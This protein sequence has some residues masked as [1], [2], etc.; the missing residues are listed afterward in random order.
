VIRRDYTA[1]RAKCD[2]EG[3][4]RICGDDN[5]EAAHIIPRSQVAPP[6]GEHEDNIVPLCRDCH[7][8]YDTGRLDILPVLTRREQ[9]KAVELHGL[10]GALRRITNDRHAA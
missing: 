3:H 6:H 7:R 10:M 4:C 2:T 8:S 5:P 1:G 9:A